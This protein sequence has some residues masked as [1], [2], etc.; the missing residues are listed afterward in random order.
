[1]P[2][3]AVPDLAALAATIGHEFSDLQLLRRAMAHRSWCAET[4]G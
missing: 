1:M 4:P 2:D 3:N